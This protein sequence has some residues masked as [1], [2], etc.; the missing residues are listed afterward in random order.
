MLAAIALILLNQMPLLLGSWY[1]YD[2]GA[3]VLEVAEESSLSGALSVGDVITGL[4]SRCNVHGA[5]TWYGCL[6]ELKATLD[7]GHTGM[8][9]AIA[10]STALWPYAAEEDTHLVQ[11][12]W[13]CCL[14]ASE[15]GGSRLCFEDLQQQQQDAN[16]HTSEGGLS[17]QVNRQDLD[18]GN[19]TGNN[20]RNSKGRT[21]SRKFGCYGARDVASQAGKRCSTARE[22]GAG[23][24]C[25]KHTFDSAG[26]RLLQVQ[27]GADEQS[28]LFLGSVEE[29][30]GSISVSDYSRRTDHPHT[31][32][33]V[34]MQVG[35]FLYY[36]ASI[37]AALALLNST[38]AF[39]LDGEGAVCAVLDLI[40]EE[41][42]FRNAAKLMIG[43]AGVLLI[44]INM[45]LALIQLLLL[46]AG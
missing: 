33:D 23:M 46:Q 38:P 12:F 42:T 44:G 5:K 18:N 10:T 8:C 2:A 3:G 43:G 25:L 39:A 20:H 21:L 15:E 30:A 1:N 29:L 45:L 35:Q 27:R 41:G 31:S 22:C 14:N 34:P 4:D 7:G 17:R 24:T 11:G 40:L 32:M 28:V 19:S 13:E 36:I 37:G 26:S 6:S 9:I 16:H